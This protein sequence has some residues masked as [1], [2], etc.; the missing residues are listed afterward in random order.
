[1]R[2]KGLLVVNQENAKNESRHTVK[3]SIA[4]KKQN[5][6][7]LGLTALDENDSSQSSRCETE[8]DAAELSGN[9]PWATIMEAEPQ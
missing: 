5:V 1:L 7:Q 4:G 2:D 9:F 3:R 6:I 8:N